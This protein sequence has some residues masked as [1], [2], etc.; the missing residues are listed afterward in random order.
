MHIT[1]YLRAE[2][3]DVKQRSKAIKVKSTA[4]VMKRLK[5]ENKN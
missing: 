1:L 2:K 5:Y 4:S 3:C